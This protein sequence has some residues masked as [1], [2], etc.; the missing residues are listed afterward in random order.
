MQHFREDVRSPKLMPDD[1]SIK[2]FLQ[3]CGGPPARSPPTPRPKPAKTGVRE[4][5]L[6]DDEE[7]LTIAPLTIARQTH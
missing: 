1:E 5:S 2:E 7:T 6:S 3:K 4:I